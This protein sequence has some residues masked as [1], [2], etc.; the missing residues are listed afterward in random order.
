MSGKGAGPLG[1]E[2]ARKVCDGLGLD[3]EYVGW[4][5]PQKRSEA[6]SEYRQLEQLPLGDRERDLWER[7]GLDGRAQA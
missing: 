1:V 6:I 2:G 4:F 5:A 3:H 7:M